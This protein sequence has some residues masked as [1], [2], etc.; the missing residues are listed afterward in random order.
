MS[1][2]LYDL[3]IFKPLFSQSAILKS[4]TFLL[5]IKFMECIVV[6]TP[7]FYVLC[8]RL[9]WYNDSDLQLQFEK[10]LDYFILIYTR[11]LYF[12]GYKELCK[13]ILFLGI[14][15]YLFIYLGNSSLYV[16]IFLFLHMHIQ[17]FMA[18]TTCLCI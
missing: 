5:I 18:L 2:V 16:W 4:C 17:V 12:S 15:S 8:L 9:D 10:L 14:A 3:V 6:A 7:T 1:R 11:K 13:Y